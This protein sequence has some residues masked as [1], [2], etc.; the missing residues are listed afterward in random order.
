MKVKERNLLNVLVVLVV[1][2]VILYGTAAISKAFQLKIW[3]HLFF[4]ELVIIVGMLA[5]N[6][7]LIHESIYL[8]P[9]RPFSKQPW[10]FGLHIFLF[11][12]IILQLFTKQ[13]DLITALSA[14]FLVAIAEELVFRGLILNQ[15]LRFFEDSYRGVGWAVALDATIFGL[16]HFVNLSSQSFLPTLQQVVQVAAMGTVF[17]AITIRSGSLLPSMTL[18][19]LNNFFSAYNNGVQEKNFSWF[20]FVPVILLLLLARVYLQPVKAGKFDLKRRLA[21]N[22]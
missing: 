4:S 22:D 3:Q 2:L 15:L 18:H 20:F 16:V 17:A 12:L 5:L 10:L 11:L 19:F 14:S 21:G 8:K 13:G 9:V 7:T 1:N 6:R